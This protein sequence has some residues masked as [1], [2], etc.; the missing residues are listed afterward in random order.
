VAGLLPTAILAL[1]INLLL[2]S[3]SFFLIEF[4]NKLSPMPFLHAFSLIALLKIF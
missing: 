4:M 1:T 2:L 3:S